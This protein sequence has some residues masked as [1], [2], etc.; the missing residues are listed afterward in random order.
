MSFPLSYKLGAVAVAL[1]GAACGLKCSVSHFKIDL[2]TAVSKA[3]FLS[4]M[5]FLT[6]EIVDR[7]ILPSIPG[8]YEDTDKPA[9][10]ASAILSTF[11]SAFA[12]AYS[13][14]KSFNIL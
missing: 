5:L 4:L 11:V 2:I 10:I 3:A 14:G 1:S 7:L 9:F 12:V 6:L 8:I 13:I